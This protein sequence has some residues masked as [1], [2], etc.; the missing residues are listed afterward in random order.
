MGSEA[1]G[2]DGVRAATRQLIKEGADFIKVMATGGSTLASD[3][4]RPAYAVDEL[5][6][7]AEEAHRRNRAVAAHCRSTV[8]MHN[9]LEAG[10]DIIIHGFFAD[11][12]ATKRFDPQVAEQIA[13]QEV[14]VNPT[15]HIGRATIWQLEEKG[16]AEGLTEEEEDRLRTV[17]ESVNKNLENCGRQNRIGGEDNRRIRLWMGPLPIRPIRPRNKRDGGGR[18]D[19]Y[20]GHSGGH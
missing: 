13:K 20:A 5:G 18:P 8:G 10:F 15:I 12:D 4:Y 7:I 6:V 1:D 14:W 17:R 2:V 9:V 16:E 11:E 19:Q 3:P